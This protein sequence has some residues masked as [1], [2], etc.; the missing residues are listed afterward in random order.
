MPDDYRDD[1]AALHAR[2]EMLEAALDVATQ[3]TAGSADAAA[4]VSRCPFCGQAMLK[5]HFKA[6]GANESFL[7]A[8]TFLRENGAEDSVTLSITRN[9][10]TMCPD[11]G[12]IVLRGRFAD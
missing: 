8:S 5:G 6:Q 10:D 4:A 3:R 9:P 11:C 1:V 12:T 7:R 2:I